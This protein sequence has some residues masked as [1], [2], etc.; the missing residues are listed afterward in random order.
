MTRCDSCASMENPEKCHLFKIGPLKICLCRKCAG[1]VLHELIA[2]TRDFS[3]KWPSVKKPSNPELPIKDANG[4][5]R[6]RGCEVQL[7]NA[8][9]AYC[10]ECRKNQTP[11]ARPVKGSSQLGA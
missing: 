1:R 2:Y 4:T 8:T 11:S 5:T 3:R 7:R 6:C 10:R 9:G